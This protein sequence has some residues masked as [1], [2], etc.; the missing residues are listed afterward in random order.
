MPASFACSSVL[1]TAAT[2]GSVKVTRGVPMP[3][4]IASTG[5][6]E[7]VL[8]RD[9]GLVLAHVGEERPAGDVADRVEPLAAADPQS[10]RRSRGSRPCRA[11]PRPIR[12]RSPS[13][14]GLRPTATSS[15]AASI[16]SPP[17]SSTSTPPSLA[18]TRSA[19]A[20]VRTSTPCLPRSAAATCSPAKGSSRA[21]IRSPPSTRVTF[22]PSVD[23]AWASSD[24]D[25]PAA[26]HDHAL[27]D[28]LRGGR[29]AVVPGVDGV[30]AL[31]RRHRRAAPVQTTTTR[32]AT[33]VRSPTTTRRSPSSRPSP[34]KSSIPRSSSQGS[35]PESSRSWITSSR[36][37]RTASGSSV[38][39]HRLR[40][41]GHAARLVEQLARAQQRL[42]GHAGVV[43]ALAADQ[44]R[45]DDRHAR[46]RRRRGARRR[47]P[48]GR[49]RRARSRRTRSRSC[50]HSDPTA[51][52]R[53]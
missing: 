39:G 34:R 27:G 41:A 35:C 53:N 4:A 47:P 50:R 20:P 1:P 37:A 2:C 26:E 43:G 16:R 42:R 8:G 5:A 3:S 38:A 36:R 7:G 12:A 21:S 49:R 13:V 24:A 45:L 25:R 51:Y 14:R 46:A 32:L 52:N 9:P 19:R 10:G 28:P 6:A 44:V 11:R 18:A 22:V 33:S 30:E 23:Q 15:S 48:P 29:V 40:H 31:D 17:S